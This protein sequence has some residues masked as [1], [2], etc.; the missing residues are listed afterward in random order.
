MFRHHH[1]APPFFC[2]NKTMFKTIKLHITTIR[3]LI[4]AGI[5]ILIASS[6]LWFKTVYSS[7]TNVFNR[8]ITNSLSSQSVSKIAIQ[9]GDS[10]NLEQASTLVTRPDQRVHS[11][12]ILSQGENLDTVI[13]TESIASPE[14]DFVR[15]NDISTTQKTPSGGVYD[16]SSILG[17]WGKSD[18]AS[19]DGNGAQLYNQTLLGVVPIANLPV[20]KRKELIK[21][22]KTDTVFKYDSSATKRQ[23][24]NGR[25][26]Y[27]YEVTVKPESYVSMLKNFS[28]TVGITQLEQIDPAQYADS[29]PLKFTF[30]IDVWS[31]QLT[32]IIYENSVRTENLTAYGVWS[33]IELP[34]TSI[35]VDEL[36]TRL[37]QIQ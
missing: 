26:V 36:Q 17:L 29:V 18:I 6:V 15:Y 3:S 31:G 5:I 9:K 10:Q 4:F 2:Y 24:T 7:P 28:K 19:K 32:K 16:F 34:A 20:A 33:Q 30:E 22:I 11:T 1:Y 13:T 8:M 25:P 35:G 27:S 23:I 37:R 21:Q 12:S 14:Y